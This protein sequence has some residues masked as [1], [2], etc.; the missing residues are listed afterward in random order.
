[1][2]EIAHPLPTK[3]GKYFWDEWGAVVDITK[4]GRSL[5]VTPPTA[6]AIPVRISRR[7][8]G[9]FVKVQEQQ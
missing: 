1:M 3:P 2:A 9:I 7:T 5:W 8:A 4:K 6:G